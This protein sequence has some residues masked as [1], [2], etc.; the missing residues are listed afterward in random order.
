M[1]INR[2]AN[3]LNPFLVVVAVG[4]LILNVTFY[5]GM[6]VSRQPIVSSAAHSYSGTADET[7]AA[8]HSGSARY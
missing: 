6:S 7:S 2:A 8:F 5:L 3:E 1:R 4:L